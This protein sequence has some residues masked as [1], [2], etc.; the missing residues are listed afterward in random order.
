VV[1]SD[2]KVRE[3]LL[4][5]KNLML[6]VAIETLRTSQAIRQRMKEM[7][8][9]ATG[10][11]NS[12]RDNVNIVKL[13]KGKGTKD[14]L[15]PPRSI[16]DPKDQKAGTGL[17]AVTKECK[18]C[19]KQHEF[20]R[21]VCPASDKICKNCGKKGHFKKMRQSKK[22]VHVPEESFSEDET[23]GIDSVKKHSGTPVLVT[24]EVNQKH[25]VTFEID[26]GASCNIL[27]FFRIC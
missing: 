13:K 20:K 24:C 1:L 18:F 8:S 11:S 5:I 26:T 3:K 15:K 21:G 27:P 19:G 14:L 22:L 16:R 23:F 6:A 17:P 25:D 9:L 10:E 7:G 12:L 2:D 4:G